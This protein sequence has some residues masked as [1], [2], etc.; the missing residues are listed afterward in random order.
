MNKYRRVIFLLLAV[1]TVSLGACAP[2]EGSAAVTTADE[3]ASASTAEVT[4]APDT[5]GNA[6]DP[7]DL[8][9]HTADLGADGKDERITVDLSDSENKVA[10][11]IYSE[12][13][14]EVW[15][16]EIERWHS[17]WCGIY[18]CR[19]GEGD[20]VLLWSPYVSQGMAFYSYELFG[21]GAGGEKI[22]VD[23]DVLTFDYNGA[24]PENAE[25]FIE[26][27][28]AYLKN[29]TVLAD[30]LDGGLLYGTP[31]SPLPAPVFD[32]DAA[33]AP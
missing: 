16:T 10:V 18:L 4:S 6:G 19:T 20:R 12:D 27:V 31:E 33:D 30:T 17:G 22:P 5:T 26:K 14:A 25:A 23:G 9:T 24:R 13:G 15:A 7:E 29:S 21:I 8:I 32:P 3:N 1:L 11:K 2:A 28:N